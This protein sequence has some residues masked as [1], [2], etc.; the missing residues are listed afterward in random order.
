[1]G[2]RTS[3]KACRLCGEG[4]G[5]LHPWLRNYCS[6]S[7]GRLI[8]GTLC[9]FHQNEFRRSVGRLRDGRKYDELTALDLDAWLT[10]V[11][12]RL[13]ARKKAIGFLNRCEVIRTS[14][15][16]FG[17]RCCEFASKVVDGHYV[18]SQHHAQSCYATPR[19]MR[20]D[21]TITRTTWLVNDAV[22][23][24]LEGRG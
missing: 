1:M 11:L 12:R 13:A 10:R 20:F 24:I 9:H 2:K 16:N 22:D 17:S 8:A 19:R 4:C 14:A 3:I 18:C 7:A 6:E 5:H 23:K 15:A 21:K